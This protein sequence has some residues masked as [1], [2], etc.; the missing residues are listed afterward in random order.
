MAKHNYNIGIRI[1][2]DLI[3]ILENWIVKN[4][5]NTFEIKNINKVKSKYERDFLDANFL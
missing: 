3:N 1:T 2:T 4:N 5:C